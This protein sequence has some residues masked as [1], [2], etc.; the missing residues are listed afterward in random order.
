[1]IRGDTD[2]GESV[3]NHCRCVVALLSLSGFLSYTKLAHGQSVVV[4]SLPAEPVTDWTSASFWETVD[5]EPP[6]SSW[7]FADGEVRLQH[8]RGGR[9][10]LVSGP[11]PTHFDLT[12]DWKIEPGTNSGLK[13]RL[14]KYGSKFL[15]LEYQ[16]IDDD[17]NAQ[18]KDSTASIYDLVQPQAKHLRPVGQWNT[19][20]IV[21][22]GKNLKHYLNGE[23]VSQATTQGA[24]W[25]LRFALSKFYGAEGF[26]MPKQDDRFM[27]T[28]HGGKASFRNFKFIAVNP[29][30]SKVERQD[31]EGPFLANAM[32]NS[33][34]NQTSIVVWTRTTRTRELNADGKKF[35]KVSTKEASKLGKLRDPEAIHA[36][37]LPEG[38]T[39]DEMFGACPGAEGEVR[40]TYFP[41][42]QRRN[43]IITPWSQ[44]KASNDFT[45]Q[46]KLEGLKPGTQY[47]A[48]VEA[49]P[50]GGSSPT[51]VIRGGFE[52]APAANKK[53]NIR[54]GVTTCHDFIRRD[55]GLKGHKIYPALTQIAPDFMVHAGDIEYYDKPD[56]WACTIDL[57][58]FK[59][60][61]I[62]SLASNRTFYQNTS[63][64][65]IKD[66]H[67][68]L[69]NDCWPGQMYG[70]VSFEQGLKLFNE[71]QF[72]S[73]DP[74]YQTV[75][76][77]RDLQIWILE[78][79]DYRSP[80]TMKDGPD[81][82]ILGSDQKQWLLETLDQSDAKFKLVFSPTPI[83]GP[84][85]ANKRDNHANEIFAHEGEEL[86]KCLSQHPGL[87][88]FCG[89]R[90]W[91]YASVDEETGLWEFGCGPGSEKHQ[92]GWK[93]G[94]ERPV[95]R[96]L[97][98]AGGFLTG[99]LTYGKQK[100]SESKLTLQHRTVDGEVVSEFVFPIHAKA[101]ENGKVPATSSKGD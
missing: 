79:R 2:L 5:G 23:L 25:D 44:T 59:W 86:R 57:M 32:R 66:D 91:Q 58:R 61:R 14:R 97:R 33:W 84:D 49:R 93:E 27:L 77:G 88:V 40:L 55:D 90:H 13:Y 89:D 9:G 71:E 69:K 21:A 51:A 74:R 12:F 28:D 47:A 34:A 29:S 95:H 18:T 3:M 73:R 17:A 15:G 50:V 99:E 76:W 26:A 10:S 37:Q 42:L 80:N 92:L 78:G 100:N 43:P 54:F 101:E 31:E 20:R 87:I 35:I 63:T 72:P 11:M 82:S 85:R 96:F 30:D 48:V 68:T 53:Q 24:D 64:Y 56:P 39:L 41:R 36:A 46:W 70:S 8:P 1:M 98:V 22:I 38:A 65:F 94:D 81:K 52:T 67:D 83:V 7:E 4:E 60:G 62:F 6:E 19:A 75:R 16:I 45:A